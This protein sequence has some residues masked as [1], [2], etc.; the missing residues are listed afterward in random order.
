VSRVLG[1][2]SDRL[3]AAIASLDAAVA[4]GDLEAVRAARADM[5]A[6]RIELDVAAALAV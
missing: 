1:S 3:A 6:L 2:L 5:N 4:A